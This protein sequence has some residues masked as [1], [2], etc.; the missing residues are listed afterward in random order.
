MSKKGK[1]D[2]YSKK[3]TSEISLILA[4]PYRGHMVYIRRIYN[5]LFL[6]DVVFNNEIYS[7]YIVMKPAIG[8]I[9]LTDS[10]VKMTRDLCFAGAAATIDEKMG[11]ELSKKDKENVDTFEAARST[12]T[13]KTVS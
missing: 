8:K 2:L 5:D 6:W 12:I 13:G 7:S 3:A 1:K 11:I 4:I 9:N 10:Q